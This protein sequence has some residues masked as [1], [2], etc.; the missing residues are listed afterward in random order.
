M[1]YPELGITTFET[2]DNKSK[3]L[4]LFSAYTGN[5]YPHVYNEKIDFKGLQETIIARNY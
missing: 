2:D 1:N 4:Y 5:E 3:K